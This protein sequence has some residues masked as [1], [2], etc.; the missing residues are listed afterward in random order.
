MVQAQELNADG[1]DQAQP[2]YLKFFVADALG[3]AALPSAGVS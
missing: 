2:F 3:D 1:I